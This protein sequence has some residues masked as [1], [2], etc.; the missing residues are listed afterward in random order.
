MNSGELSIEVSGPHCTKHKQVASGAIRHA[1]V[2][3]HLSMRSRPTSGSQVK[4][5]Q[6]VSRYVA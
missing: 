4:A 2:A 3:V 6:P 1:L 5:I